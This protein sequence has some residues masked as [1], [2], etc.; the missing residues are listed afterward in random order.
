MEMKWEITPQELKQ[1][2]DAGDELQLIDVRTPEEFAIANIGGMLLPVSD[3]L[4]RHHELNPD[5]ETVV[6]C[7]HGIRSAQAAV[8]LSQLGFSQV[9]SLRGGLER[10]SNEVDPSLP[11]Y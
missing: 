2:L 9:L 11:R 5:K 1:R 6:I 4:M 10:W 3:L 7:H 8:L